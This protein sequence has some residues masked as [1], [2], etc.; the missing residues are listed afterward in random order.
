METDLELGFDGPGDL[1]L[2][3]PDWYTDTYIESFHQTLLTNYDEPMLGIQAVTV[4][5]QQT[6]SRCAIK[7]HYM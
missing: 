1:W 7:F 5:V 3:W 2:L 6:L 4:T